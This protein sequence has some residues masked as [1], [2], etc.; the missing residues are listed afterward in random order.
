MSDIPTDQATPHFLSPLPQAGFT[1]VQHQL[2]HAKP[3]PSPATAPAPAILAGRHRPLHHWGQNCAT[4]APV[5]P[6]SLP[7]PSP[8]TRL[9]VAAEECERLAPP[10]PVPVP[11]ELPLPVVP[12]R[13]GEAE[14]GEGAETKGPGAEQEGMSS[15]EKNMLKV[16]LER[17]PE[18]KMHNV[19]QIVQ[20]MSASNLELLGDATELDID[21]MDIETLWE[22]DRF[23]TNFNKAL[24]K[25][26]RAAMMNGDSPEINDAAGSEAVN[27]P[28]PTLVHNADVVLMAIRNNTH[29]HCLQLVHMQILILCSV[30]LFTGG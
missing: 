27:G 7:A 29:C 8:H 19:M 26:R 18:E 16:G 1:A 9:A 17:L 4:F 28:V 10:I 15:E 24:N 6:P 25:S 5:P 23:V 2:Q 11:A 21:E 20:K 22:L 3:S 30:L 12:A 14:G 13:T